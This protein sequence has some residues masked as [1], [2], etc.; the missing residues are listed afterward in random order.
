ML[1]GIKILIERMN[2]DP[3]KFSRNYRLCD[4]VGQ[5][6]HDEHHVNY[7]KEEREAILEAHR[8]MT[9]K[10]FTAN[11]VSNLDFQ[12]DYEEIPTA[13]PRT[14]YPNLSGRLGAKP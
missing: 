13:V 11:V 7:T 8:R 10:I 2:E 1:E 5:I 4:L 9:R 12:P 6:I 3:D 14:M